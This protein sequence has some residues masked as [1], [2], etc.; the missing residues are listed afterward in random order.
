MTDTPDAAGT[1][2]TAGT[3]DT[4]DTAGTTAGTAPDAPAETSP[5]ETSGRPAP[6]YTST[7]PSVP[8]TVAFTGDD[9]ANALIAT[10]PLAL[11]IA[12]LLN[13]QLP[14]SYAFRSP[15]ELKER[16]GGTLDAAEI[17]SADPE[18]FVALFSEDPPLHRVPAPWAKRTQVLCQFVVDSHGGRAEDIWEPAQTGEE[19]LARVSLLPG[20]TKQKALEFMAIL[21][22]QLDVKPP[23]WEPIAGHYVDREWFSVS[24][25]PRLYGKE[26]RLAAGGVE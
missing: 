9:E 18:A 23:G 20:F 1:P 17:A 25:R 19:L 15:L 8:D 10:D 3:T 14:K 5:A 16:M 12:T 21:A 4:A 22:T 13:Q 7:F 11:L 24:P 2:G 26:A 6:M